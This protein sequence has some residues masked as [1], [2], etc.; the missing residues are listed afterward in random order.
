MKTIAVYILPRATS[1]YQGSQRYAAL[2]NLA[3]APTEP[4]KR[5]RNIR[6]VQ[7]LTLKPAPRP[8]HRGDPSEDQNKSQVLPW[9]DPWYECHS[10][11]SMEESR[12]KAIKMGGDLWEHQGIKGASIKLNSES[13]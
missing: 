13:S 7:I 5:R 4:Q 1:S 8:K 2:S 12:F 6:S 10:Q 11:G 3:N 9:S